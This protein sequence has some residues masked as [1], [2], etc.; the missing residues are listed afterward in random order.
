MGNPGDFEIIFEL[1]YV[2]DKLDIYAG[3]IFDCPHQYFW[4]KMGIHE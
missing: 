4:G 3:Q 2:L 1:R